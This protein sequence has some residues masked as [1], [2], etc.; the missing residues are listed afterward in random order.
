MQEWIIALDK[1]LT[2]VEKALGIK[3][4]KTLV[5]G[6]RQKVADQPEIITKIPEESK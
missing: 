3:P 2:A 1:R 5:D 6:N 4:V